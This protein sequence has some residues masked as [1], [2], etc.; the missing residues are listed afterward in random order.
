MT[1]KQFYVTL[2]PFADP[3]DT[4]TLVAGFRY[5]VAS[6]ETFTLPDLAAGE[7]IEVWNATDTGTG[8]NATLNGTT[9]Q[10]VDPDT[11]LTGASYALAAGESC[12]IVSDGAQHYV[13]RNSGGGGGASTFAGLTD[14]PAYAGNA[15]LTPRVNAAETGLEYV[16]VST[17]TQLT[18]E[19][20]NATARLALADNVGQWVYQTDDTDHLYFQIGATAS[21]PSHWMKL[22]RV[23]TNT[24]PATL[25]MSL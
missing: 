16:A 20:A 1:A 3:A 4:S 14:T 13:R 19:V 12:M 7:W 18:G 24:L 23:Q 5:R 25:P 17:G 8:G 9:F 15:L 6:A 11:G 21:N 2:N 10:F 22:L